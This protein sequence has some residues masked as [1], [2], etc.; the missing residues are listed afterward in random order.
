MTSQHG[1]RIVRS[2]RVVVAERGPE[3]VLIDLDRGHRFALNPLGARIWTM[4]VSEPTLP[5]LVERFWTEYD[6]RA[7]PLAHDIAVL[8]AQWDNSGLIGWR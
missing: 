5:E 8:L 1:A 4:L 2:P 6:V 3:A 7:A